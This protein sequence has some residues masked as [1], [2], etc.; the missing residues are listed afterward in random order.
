MLTNTVSPVN[1]VGASL[2]TPYS[3][4]KAGLAVNTRAAK[5]KAAVGGPKHCKKSAWNRLFAGRGLGSKLSEWLD[6]IRQ[7]AAAS[8]SCG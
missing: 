8:K 3:S 4:A 5:A 7:I 1:N 2:S 6:E